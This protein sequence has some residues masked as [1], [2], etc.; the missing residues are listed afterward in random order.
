VFSEV[1]CCFDKM[2]ASGGKKKKEE[3]KNNKNSVQKLY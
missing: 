1:Y 2:K 3:T